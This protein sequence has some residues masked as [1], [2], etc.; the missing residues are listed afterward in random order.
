VIIFFG[1]IRLVL[2]VFY[3]LLLWI[4]IMNTRDGSLPLS[5]GSH[6]LVE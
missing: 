2:T 6:A 1:F 4:A 5:Q 3:V